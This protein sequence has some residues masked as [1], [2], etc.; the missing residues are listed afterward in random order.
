MSAPFLLT[1][2]QLEAQL[3]VAKLKDTA[4]QTLLQ[5]AQQEL[6]QQEAEPQRVDCLSKAGNIS[7]TTRDT[8]KRQFL[9]M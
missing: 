6:D 1:K 9:K 7:R 3:E 2:A 5:V 8:C 4:I